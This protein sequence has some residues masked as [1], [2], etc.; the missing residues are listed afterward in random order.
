MTYECP[1]NRSKAGLSPLPIAGGN[2]YSFPKKGENK[3][4]HQGDCPGVVLRVD[5]LVDWMARAG[6]CTIVCPG[7]LWNGTGTRACAICIN[8]MSDS[9]YVRAWEAA[10]D[11]YCPPSPPLSPPPSP[12]T[13]PSAPP[14]P[15]LS[16]P[17][18]S[19]P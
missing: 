10:F 8:A 17:P 13:P 5:F 9:E 11:D 1:G 16:P 6:N 2:W 18:A 19:P 14:S 3:E 7:D 12:S 4:W 15:P